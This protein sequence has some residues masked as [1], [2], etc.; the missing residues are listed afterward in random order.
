MKALLVTVGV[1]LSGLSFSAT[2]LAQPDTFFARELRV[3][4]CVNDVCVQVLATETSSGEGILSFFVFDRV[5]RAPIVGPV[6]GDNHSLPAGSL[7]VN[8]QGTERRSSRE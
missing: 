1:L 7:A 6:E 3:G 5:T 8:N 2:V 4:K